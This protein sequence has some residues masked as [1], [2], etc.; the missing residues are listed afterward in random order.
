MGAL[1]RPFLVARSSHSDNGTKMW[2]YPCPSCP[3]CSLS[4]ELSMVEI[5]TQIHKVLDHEPDPN[6][7]AGPVPLRE[8]VAST[9]VS[10]FGPV[11]VV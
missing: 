11:L 8:G 7:V 5:N 4:E 2:L 9:R 10:L 6:P 3:N 1:P